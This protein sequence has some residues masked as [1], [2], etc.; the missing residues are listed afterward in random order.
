MRKMSISFFC[1]CYND[2]G[3]IASMV[4]LMDK[5]ARTITDDYE[6]IVIDDGSSDPSRL[7]LRELEQRYPRL[8]LIFHEK[9]KGYG[10][11]LQAGFY[12]AKKEF[13]FY[14]DGDFQYDVMEMPKL[15]ALMNDDIDIVNGYKISRSDPLNRIIIGY[16]YQYFMKFVFQFKIRDVDCDFRLMRRKIFDGLDLKYNSGVVCVEM[17]RKMQDKGVRFAEVPVSHYHRV[18]GRSQFFNF[19]R[20]YHVARDLS[21]LW[22]QLIGSK[23]FAAKKNGR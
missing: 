11:A 18:Y 16:V 20:L 14:T 23:A 5:V 6:L 15:V 22:W 9:N 8:R 4:V 12:A 13:I 3:S 21:K 19:V 2:A 7:I 17:I 10:G 1:P